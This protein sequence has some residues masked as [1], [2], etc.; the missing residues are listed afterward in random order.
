M[1]NFLGAGAAE[2]HIPAAV[3]DIISR[4]E[5]DGHIPPYQAEASQG[6]L[7]VIYEFQSMMAHLTAMD[8]SNASLYDGGSGTV[9]S[10]ADG[11]TCASQI[12]IAPRTRIGERESVLS[13]RCPQYRRK[14]GHRMVEVPFD[15]ELGPSIIT[16]ETHAGQDFGVGYSWPSFSVRWKMYALT[17][18]AH[19]NSMLV[20]GVVNPDR[21]GGIDAAA[22]MGPKGADIVIGEGQPLGVPCYRLAALMSV[23]FVAAK[24]S[25]VRCLVVVIGRPSILTASPVLR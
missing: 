22:R 15:K 9:R 18:W 1:V 8:I 17:D 20:V 7:Q 24:R 5:F 4:G 13:Q 12:K 25:C 6:T 2:H 10:R 23:L 16:L 14:P 21:A 11:G 19:A 3:W